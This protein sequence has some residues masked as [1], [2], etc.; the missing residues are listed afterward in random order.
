MQL[1]VKDL[2]E[3]V[4]IAAGLDSLTD[5]QR[6]QVERWIDSAVMM[7]R[8]RFGSLDALEQSA[9]EYVISEAVAARLMRPGFGRISTEVAVD[10]A[11]A[12]TRYSGDGST[13]LISDDLWAYLQP[14]RRARGAMSVPLA[15]QSGYAP[16][17]YR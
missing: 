17:A 16:G 5:L 1:H 15:Y 12:V 10:D 8:N 14:R 13:V 3:Q 11:R 2:I 6:S 4:R 9:V 7:I